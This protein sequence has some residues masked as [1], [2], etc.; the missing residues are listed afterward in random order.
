MDK[1]KPSWKEVLRTTLSIP[2]A[3]MGIGFMALSFH[4]AILGGLSYSPRSN[5]VWSS[6]GNPQYANIYRTI[7]FSNSYKGVVK[8]KHERRRR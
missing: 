6:S 7:P 2:I 3:I 8:I 1:E 4:L 5:D